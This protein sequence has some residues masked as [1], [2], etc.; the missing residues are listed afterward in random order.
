MPTGSGQLDRRRYWGSNAQSYEYDVSD[1]QLEVNESSKSPDGIIPFDIEGIG[2]E[3]ITGSSEKEVSFCEG[4]AGIAGGY[5]RI[6]TWY[7]YWKV[8]KKTDIMRC[9]KRSCLLGVVL[10]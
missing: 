10:I 8:N 1:F 7:V 9:R 6:G 5:H 2:F 3:G 4:L